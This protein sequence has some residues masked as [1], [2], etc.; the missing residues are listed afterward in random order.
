MTNQVLRQGSVEARL[1]VDGNPPIRLP[2]FAG[3]TPSGGQVVL[4]I[5]QDPLLGALSGRQLAILDYTDGAGS[6]RTT[7]EF[8]LPGL[9]TYRGTFLAACAG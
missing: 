8:P 3:T 4:T 5:P 7:A 2:G 1:T 6:S 9:E